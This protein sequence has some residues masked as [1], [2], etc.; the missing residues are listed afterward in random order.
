MLSDSGYAEYCS[1]KMLVNVPYFIERKL[2]FKDEYEY[3]DTEKEKLVREINILKAYHNIAT[4]TGFFGLIIVSRIRKNMT[5]YLLAFGFGYI[6]RKYA[7][8]K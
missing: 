6:G 1:D 4:L 3:K 8:Y 7:N 2:D 5:W